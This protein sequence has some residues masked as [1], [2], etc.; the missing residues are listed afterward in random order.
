[1]QIKNSAEKFGLMTR[2]LHWII[3]LAIIFLIWLGWYMVDLT[4]YD[5]WYNGSLTWHKSLGLIVL[6]LA[7]I[8]IGWQIYSPTPGP[9]ATLKPWEKTGARIMHVIL[10]FMMV[11]IPATGYLISTSDGKAVDVFG[12]FSVPALVGKNTEVRDLAINLHFYLAYGTALL[13]AGHIGAALKHQFI[14]KDGTLTRML[15]K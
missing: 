11:L 6:G 10:T 4:Y 2:L 3:G 1:M 7:L 14:N 15:W 8:K 13:L 9:A 5:K 12:W